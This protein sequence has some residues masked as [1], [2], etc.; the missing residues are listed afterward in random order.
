[1][2]VCGSSSMRSARAA[3]APG[4]AKNSFEMAACVECKAL[5]SGELCNWES[6]G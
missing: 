3:P 5:R 2:L 6:A 4:V 1:M